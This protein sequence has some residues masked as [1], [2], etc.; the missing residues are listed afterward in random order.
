MTSI[1]NIDVLKYGPYILE[2]QT[3]DIK[4][5]CEEMRL[6]V[7]NLSAISFLSML[8]KFIQ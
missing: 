7:K 2:C 3:D 4:R 5:G 8:V 6:L 1:S